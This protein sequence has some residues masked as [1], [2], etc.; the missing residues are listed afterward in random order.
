MINGRLATRGSL[1]RLRAKVQELSLASQTSHPHHPR[2]LGLPRRN[3]SQRHRA[4]AQT[5]LRPPAARVS[6]HAD[7]HQRPLRRPARR[8]N[9]QQRSRPSQH[10]R[11]PHR[12]HGHHPHRPDDPERRILLA[13]RP[14]RGH[15]AC[16]RGRAPAAS[17]RP[18]SPTAASTRTKRI[19]T[20]CSKMAKQNDVE[21]VFVHAFMDGRDTLPTNG[22][23]YL[24]Q[25]QQKMREYNFG[26]IASVNGRYYAM[27]RDRRWERIAKA[28]DAMVHRRR[29]RRALRRPG[30]GHERLLQQRRHR[31]I[32]HAVRLHRQARRAASPPSATTMSASASTSAPTACAR[33]PAPSP[34][35]AASTRKPA[36]DLPG[37]A[38]LDATI[39]RAP[40]PQESAL[41][42]HDAVRQKFHAAGRHPAGIDGEHSGQRDGAN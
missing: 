40:R 5:H 18:A 15:E 23:G 11:R 41:R 1:L 17:L 29:R 9:G 25:L 37:A 30:A 13:S 42:L 10:R 19:S 14:A 2:R 32:R 38:D 21:R 4:G 27:D 35:T 33:S 31:R 36:R 7:P 20:R 34:A 3:Q 28:F 8:P 16:P 39:P 22:A 12:P 6:Q 26:K 24:E